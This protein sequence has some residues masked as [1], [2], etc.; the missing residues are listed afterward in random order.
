MKFLLALPLSLLAAVLS[1]AG[2]VWLTDLDAA[3]AQGLK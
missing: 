2:P 1:A 3:K